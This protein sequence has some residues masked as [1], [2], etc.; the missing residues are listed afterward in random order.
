MGDV[1]NM[2]LKKATYLTRFYKLTKQTIY[3]YEK[4]NH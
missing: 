1:F 3:K 4:S 2:F